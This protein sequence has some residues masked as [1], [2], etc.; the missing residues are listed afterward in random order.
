MHC[1]VEEQ[2]LLRIFQQYHSS[3]ISIAFFAPSL[4][5]IPSLEDLL[6]V[7]KFVD[8]RSIVFVSPR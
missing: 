2:N 6:Q 4:A 7:L 5:V 3:N 1:F 8:F